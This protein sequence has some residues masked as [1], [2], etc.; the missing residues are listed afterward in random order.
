MGTDANRGHTRE[1]RANPFSAPRSFLR[2]SL[3][4][5]HYL[6]K[7]CSAY[8]RE[9]G[10]REAYRQTS[11]MEVNYVSHNLIQL[12]SQS[13]KEGIVSHYTDEEIE[14]QTIIR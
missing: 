13:C 7:T 4:G 3:L 11:N 14:A 9:A 6:S 1:F 8:A 2:K 12:S 10:K 5:S